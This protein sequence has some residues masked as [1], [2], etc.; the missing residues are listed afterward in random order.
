MYS[1]LESHIQTCHKRSRQCDF[2]LFFEALPT[3]TLQNIL[4]KN[5][6][7]PLWNNESNPNP[8]IDFIV[9]CYIIPTFW[10]MRGDPYSAPPWSLKP[11]GVRSCLDIFTCT[12]LHAILHLTTSDPLTLG[13]SLFSSYVTSGTKQGL[14]TAALSSNA[15]RKAQKICPRITM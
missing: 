4:K 3:E 14:E 8:K 10:T 7:K 2:T 11:H 9:N 5:F 1:T 13:T 12:D 6:P 15:R